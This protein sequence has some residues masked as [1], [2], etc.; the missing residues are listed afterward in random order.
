[1][2]QMVELMAAYSSGP[3]MGQRQRTQIHGESEKGNGV[4]ATATVLLLARIALP[5]RLPS[6]SS[7]SILPQFSSLT[8]VV[9]LADVSHELLVKVS[10]SPVLT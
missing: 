4:I 8:V 2:D 3:S 1:M 10:V 7:L 9:D 5:G 6:F